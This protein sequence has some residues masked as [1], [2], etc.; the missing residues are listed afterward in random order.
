MIVE[1]VTLPPDALVARRA[2]ADGALPRLGRPDHRRRTAC[3]SASS[4][5]ATC[6]S[7][8][9]R[10]SRIAR[11]DDERGPRH[12]AGR[13]DARGGARRS[14]AATRSRS[15]RSSTRRGH[16]KGLITV[17]DIQKREQ[18][19]ARDEGRA[20]AGCASAPPSASGTDAL[21][22]AAALVGAEV[23][24]LVVDTAHGHSRGSSRRCGEIKSR[25]DVE[26]IAGNIA[27][28]RGGR[29]ADRGGRRRLK[30][31]VG[32]GHRS[33][34]PASS[35]ASACRRSP[36]STTSRERPWSTACP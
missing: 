3:S 33:A 35:P 10:R 9:T 23:D 13:H 36:P 19:P 31:G 14:S 12:R 7:A 16:L 20:G 24:V 28:G 18:L 1:P 22:R 11:R 32:P 25:F 6:A 4:P 30:V 2:R 29:G 8:P 5:T 34:R 21:E 26:V 15:S 17:K 27:T